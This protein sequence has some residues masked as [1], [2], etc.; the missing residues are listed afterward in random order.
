MPVSFIPALGDAVRIHLP[1]WHTTSKQASTAQ[2]QFTAFLDDHEFQQLKNGMKV[3][4]WTNI[5]SD[6]RRNGEWGA[7]DFELDDELFSIQHDS[8]AIPLS[9]GPS[10]VYGSARDA[11]HESPNT[12]SRHVL[13]AKFSV[14]V[15]TSGNSFSFTYRLLYPSGEERW[16]GSYGQNGTLYL[17]ISSKPDESGFALENDWA[18]TNSDSVPLWQWRSDSVVK[19]LRVAE[20]LHPEDWSVCCVGK[21]GTLEGPD[22]ANPTHLFVV[23]RVRPYSILRPKTFAFRTSSDI[24][25]S[26]ACTPGG[27]NAYEVLKIFASGSGS[28]FLEVCDLGN[29]SIKRI[30]STHS[31]TLKQIPSSSG[32]HIVLVH[33]PSDAH[34]FNGTIVPL[35]PSSQRAVVQIDLAALASLLGPNVAKFALFAP[36]D[37]GVRFVDLENGQDQPGFGQISFSVSPV[38][39]QFTLSPVYSLPNGDYEEDVKDVKVSILSPHSVH[40]KESSADDFLPTPPPSPHLRPIAHLSPTHTSNL[41][42][43]LNGSSASISDMGIPSRRDSPSSRPDESEDIDTK[44]NTPKFPE[45]EVTEGEEGTAEIGEVQDMDVEAEEDGLQAG[46]DG[47]TRPSQSESSSLV[48]RSSSSSSQVKLSRGRFSI[49]MSLV[50]NLFKTFTLWLLMLIHSIFRSGHYSRQVEQQQMDPESRP[51]TPAPDAHDSTRA[52]EDDDIREENISFPV[53]DERTPLLSHSPEPLTEPQQEQVLVLRVDPPIVDDKKQKTP[54]A[55]ESETHTS[56][57][58]VSQQRQPQKTFLVADLLGLGKTAYHSMLI[59][60]GAQDAENLS[61]DK[62]IVGQVDIELN[63]QPVVVS[64]VK[65][66]EQGVVLVKFGEKVPGKL[67]LNLR[68]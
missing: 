41:N 2:L 49:I 46:G 32:C 12:E 3:Q 24:S 14:P 10:S 21:E 4:I 50:K 35:I 27:S 26:T 18:L 13:T 17:G 16:L 36:S 38:G 20:F 59:S 39:G 65:T 58:M 11:A 44:H 60:I 5:P 43:N 23:P 15:S 9:F 19:D 6:E 29:S 25:L 33:S 56:P 64:D 7:M 53:V 37:F 34:P 22:P 47:T 31:E 45:S 55:T 68:Q 42:G 57:S 67:R 28:I 54:I 40:V 63:G 62:A 30:L 66:L 1:L 48:R 51:Q 8:S 61:S 52:E